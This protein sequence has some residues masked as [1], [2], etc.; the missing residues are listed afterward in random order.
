MRCEVLLFAQLAEALETR[1]LAIELPDGATVGDALDHLSR[2]HDAIA[3]LRAKLAIAV[4]EA[5]QPFSA[6]L[7]DG[8]RVALIPPVSGG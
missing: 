6:P 1:Q 5:Y 4:D 3:A 7:S 2:A 8:C